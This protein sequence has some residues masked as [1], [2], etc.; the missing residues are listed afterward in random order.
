VPYVGHRNHGGYSR[1]S[2]RGDQD[3][4]A[5]GCRDNG[6]AARAG[7]STGHVAALWRQGLSRWRLP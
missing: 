6:A 2:P 5:A 1:I 4:S 3:E 7:L